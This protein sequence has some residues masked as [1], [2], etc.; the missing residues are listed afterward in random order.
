MANL[1]KYSAGSHA[2]SHSTTHSF[3]SKERGMKWQM[4]SVDAAHHQ[5]L[6]FAV[7]VLNTA[8]M[9]TDV[10]VLGFIESSHPEAPPNSKLAAFER[11]SRL[12]VGDQRVVQLCVG[13]ALPLVDE[14]G[15][16]N[17]LE[18]SYRVLAGV[19]GG[20]GGDGA[21]ATIGTIVVRRDR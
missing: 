17:I 18:G 9:V 10:V 16:E 3:I 8:G 12:E 6:C 7:T 21:G 11:E 1:E 5:H 2:S 19:K 15:I 20:I 4:V 13:S 14:N